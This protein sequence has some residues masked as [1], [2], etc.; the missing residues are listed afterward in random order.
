MKRILVAV[1]YPAAAAQPA[2]DK[3]LVLAR[4]SGARLEV[5]HAAF[6]PEAGRYGATDSAREVELLRGVRRAQLQRLVEARAAPGVAVEIRVEWAYPAHE[7]IARAAERLRADVVVGQSQRRGL[8]RRLLTYTDW[9][10]IRHVRRPLLLVKSARP[11]A[12]R[13]VLAAIDPLHA[14][15]KPAALDGAILRAGKA[16]ARRAGGALRVVHAFPAAVRYLPGTLRV[17]VPTLAPPAEQRRRARAVRARVLRV[18]EA[19]GI[20]A[21]RVHVESGDAV[22]VVPELARRRDAG[23]VVVGAI[24]RSLLQRWLVGATAERLLDELAADVL[25]V[26]PAPVAARRQ[27]RPRRTG[28]RR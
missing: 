14:H 3:A 8:V 24:S 27:R 12:G 1:E 20:P 2:L 5:Y 4:A 15:A 11:W 9:Q 23:V 16:L 10:L 25:V 6:D 13:D 21:S 26:H 18:T 7:A 17:P 28:D 19:A 22:D